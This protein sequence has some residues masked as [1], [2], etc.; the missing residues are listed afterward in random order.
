MN[1]LF[2]LL[3]LFLMFSCNYKNNQNDQITSSTSFVNNGRFK[4]K[5]INM[6]FNE[7]QVSTGIDAEVFKSGDE[8]VIISAPENIIDDII[9][10]KKGSGVHIY[11]S[12]NNRRTNIQGVK[13]TIY[14]KNLRA[15]KA[16][17]S[18]DIL[19]R[20][21]F[22]SERMDVSVSS[23]GS[24]KG[25]IEANDLTIEASSSGDFHG[26]IWANNLTTAASSSGDIVIEGNVKQAKL[27]ASSSG[28]I[29]ARNLKV[30]TATLDASSS[31][32]IIVGVTHSATASASS[33]GDVKIIKLGNVS[34]SKKTSSGGSV[35]VE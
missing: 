31:G 10:E 23:S 17:S 32:D 6:S 2:L 27:E 20:D 15:I 18:G 30:Q 1:K 26:R 21:K 14:V 11:I 28:D 3:A 4:T 9:V 13:A 19:L 8:K 7:I 5:T 35:D 16:N 29:K 34:V 24:V 33:A 25:D 22:L 12:A